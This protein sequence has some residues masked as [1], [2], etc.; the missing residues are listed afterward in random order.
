MTGVQTCALRS[1]SHTV[2]KIPISTVAGVLTSTSGPIIAIFHQYAHKHTGMT[3]HFVNQL[4]SFGIQVHASPTSFGSRP[5]CL[6]T[7]Y[8]YTIPLHIR[9]GLPYMDMYAPNPTEL[10]SYPHVFFISNYHWSPTSL[11]SG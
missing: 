11:P 2:K 1:D 5:P 6:V 3:V 7:P 9:N 10:E 4:E 8:G